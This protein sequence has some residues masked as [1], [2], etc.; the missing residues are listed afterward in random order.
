MVSTVGVSS[1]GVLVQPYIPVSTFKAKRCKVH[2]LLKI[3][4]SNAI[5]N[6]YFLGSIASSTLA[7]KF[8]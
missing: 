6:T 4:Q 2:I 7:Q 5:Q 1:G 8:R 3:N